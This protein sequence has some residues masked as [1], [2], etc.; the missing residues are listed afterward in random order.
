MEGIM[1]GAATVKTTSMR[2]NT[3]LADEA[4]RVMGAKS[5]TEAVHMA[6]ELAVETT[7]F[8]KLMDKYSGKLKFEGV[9]EGNGAS[10]TG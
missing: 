4:M 1:R 5:R 6:L 3:G 10:V 7:R 8:H 2:L 9:D